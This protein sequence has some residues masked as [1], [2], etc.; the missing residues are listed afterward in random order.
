[1]EVLTWFEPISAPTTSG[2]ATVCELF[3][4][5]YW[6]RNDC[7]FSILKIKDKSK[8]YRICKRL[9]ILKKS[10]LMYFVI[11]CYALILKVHNCY[12]KVLKIIFVKEG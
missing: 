3:L 12:D 5:Y 2:C 6:E 11:W 8:I 10:N 9:A 4:Y 7:I 1:M